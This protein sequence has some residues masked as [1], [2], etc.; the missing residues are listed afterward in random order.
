MY[1]QQRMNEQNRLLWGTHQRPQNGN[2]QKSYR[3]GI[4]RTF[5]RLLG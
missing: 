2:A 4:E 3:T 1:Y 5:I